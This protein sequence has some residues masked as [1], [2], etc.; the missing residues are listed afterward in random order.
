MPDTV[1]GVLKDLGKKKKDVRNK[2]LK[3]GC[4]LHLIGADMTQRERENI[5]TGAIFVGFFVCF[6]LFIFS[7]WINAWYFIRT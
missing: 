6:H 1:L 3:G 7:N 5:K 4:G 2:P